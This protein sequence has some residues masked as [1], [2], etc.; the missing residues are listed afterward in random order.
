MI[1]HDGRTSVKGRSPARADPI[2]ANPQ[3]TVEPAIPPSQAIM[4]V[5]RSRCMRID[6]KD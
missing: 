2:V 1:E 3:G 6:E 4:D 5:M